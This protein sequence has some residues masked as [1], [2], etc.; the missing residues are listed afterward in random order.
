MCLFWV[1]SPGLKTVMQEEVLQRISPLSGCHKAS[2]LTFY[3]I[4]IFFILS[5]VSI[6]KNSPANTVVPNLSQQSIVRN[7]MHLKLSG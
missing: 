2:V 1:H 6:D 4:L 3:N 7:A 5:R